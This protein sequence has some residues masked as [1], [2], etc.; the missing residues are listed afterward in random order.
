M[1]SLD[2]TSKLSTIHAI[3]RIRISMYYFY[4]HVSM[5]ESPRGCHGQAVA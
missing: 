2:I 3:M 1:E 5:T 4:P